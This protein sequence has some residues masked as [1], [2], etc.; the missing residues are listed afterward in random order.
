VYDPLVSYIDPATGALILQGI[1]AVLLTAGVY[2]RR[3]L[4]APLTGIKKLF[5]N[6]PDEPSDV[7]D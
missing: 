4:L 3:V 5:S 6:S 7:Q 1:L 2:F